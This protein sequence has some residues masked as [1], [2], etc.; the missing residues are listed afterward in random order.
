MNIFDFCTY[1]T[2]DLNKVNAENRIK[3]KEE[4]DIETNIV[5]LNMEDINEFDLYNGVDDNSG[6]LDT[7]ILESLLIDHIGKFPHY[8]VFAKG[9][10]WNGASG[11]KFCTNIIDTVARNYDITLVLDKTYDKGIKCIES[12][13]DVP[14]G[15]PTYIIGLTEADYEKLE[16]A[17]FSEI[18]KFIDTLN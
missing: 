6:E 7:Y 16:D 2:V 3:A 15:S 8:L 18:E 13:H 14:T 1:Y 11:Y 17:D 12:S 4:L 10:K 5:R 9:C